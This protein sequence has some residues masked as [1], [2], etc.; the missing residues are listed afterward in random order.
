[1]AERIAYSRVSL[2]RGEHRICHPFREI[3]P[4]R[5]SQ[6]FTF[7]R[8][9]P[10][11]LFRPP[12]NAPPSGRSRN[13]RLL[14]A[15]RP[16]RF[17]DPSREPVL[18]TEGCQPRLSPVNIPMLTLSEPGTPVR[19]LEHS[20]RSRTSRST[21]NQ[22]P[23][24]GHDPPVTASFTEEA[25][26]TVTHGP[27]PAFKLSFKLPAD[28]PETVCSRGR[29]QRWPDDEKHVLARELQDVWLA[30]VPRRQFSS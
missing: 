30:S 17:R 3:D 6:R 26:G 16:F 27:P 1:M 4:E 22:L 13:L 15:E 2:N 28:R 18:P 5:S 12:K 14:P 9:L 29:S 10:K 8:S 24:V 25:V 23:K 7:L 20:I 21:S 19:K 11:A